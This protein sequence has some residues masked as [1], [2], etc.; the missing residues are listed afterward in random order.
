[1]LMEGR[2]RD[3]LPV[4]VLAASALACC[5][6]GSALAVGAGALS[7]VVFGGLA[8]AVPVVAIASGTLD[9]SRRRRRAHRH[10]PPEGTR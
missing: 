6:V 1:M 4:L 5:F 3:E 7:A 2:G 8:G 9:W 10:S